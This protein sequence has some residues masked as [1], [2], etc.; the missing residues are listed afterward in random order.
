MFVKFGAKSELLVALNVFIVASRKIL[1]V[2]GS[3]SSC[4]P[5]FVRSPILLDV[6]S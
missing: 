6:P 4:I 5:T 1:L 3:L 2:E